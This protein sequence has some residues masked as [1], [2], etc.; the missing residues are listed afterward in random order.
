MTKTNR[1]TPP[2]L[3]GPDSLTR[4]HQQAA[5][6]TTDGPST[7]TVIAGEGWWAEALTKALLITG[8]DGLDQLTNASAL[9]IDLDGNRYMTPDL[10]PAL[11]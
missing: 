4:P 10:T 11:R 5:P 3:V 9:I 6:A 1:P 2:Q 7:V 8:I